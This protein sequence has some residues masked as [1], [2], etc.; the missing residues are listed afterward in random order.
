MI[1]LAFGVVLLAA[2]H[3][4]AAVPSLKSRMKQRTGDAAYGAVFGTASLVAVIVIILG[5]RLSDFVAVYDPPEWGRHVN[6][7]LTAI[8][9][10]CLGVFLCRGRLRQWLRFPMGFATV[11][12]ATG[13]LFANGDL[14]SI[15]LFGGLLI[16]GALHIIVGL[17]NGVRPSPEVRGGH[18][19][20]S[21][22]IG[23]AL[24]A[25]MSQAHVLLIG[26]P[27]FPLN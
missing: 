23:L 21:I 14:A 2:L 17:T 13:H 6:Y 3:V 5:W 15:I 4:V 10:V 11:F 27:V 12:W 25:M 7:L 26:V 9:F 18:D 19:L 1:V 8:A 22:L 16:Y 20:F 24:Y